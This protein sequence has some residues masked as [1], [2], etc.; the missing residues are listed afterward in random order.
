MES[1]TGR[2]EKCSSDGSRLRQDRAVQASDSSVQNRQ[3]VAKHRRAQRADQKE[4]KRQDEMVQKLP[5]YTV[6]PILAKAQEKSVVVR[7]L[8]SR[9][10][11]QKEDDEEEVEQN[12]TRD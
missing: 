12:P 10:E 6:L 7:L 3:I 8:R 2:S 11:V 9:Q 4:R 1:R 5:R